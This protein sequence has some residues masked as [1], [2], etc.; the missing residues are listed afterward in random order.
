MTTASKSYWEEIIP[1]WQQSGCNMTEF[2]R[3]K[4]LS[5]HTFKYWKYKLADS[6]NSELVPKDLVKTSEP[7]KLVL[8]IINILFFLSYRFILALNLYIN[9]NQRP[10]YCILSLSSTHIYSNFK[11][12]KALCSHI[13]QYLVA[14]SICLDFIFQINPFKV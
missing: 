10:T 5:I 3:R 12:Y 8:N 4:C 13:R 11:H 7:A 1:K 9:N 2:C 6:K 14:Y